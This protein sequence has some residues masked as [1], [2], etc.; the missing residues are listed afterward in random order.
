MLTGTKD[1]D[2]PSK[3]LNKGV[4]FF[5]R[6]DTDIIAL[7]KQL[8]ELIKI[9]ISQVTSDHEI[10]ENEIMWSDFIYIMTNP[11][12]RKEH[13]IYSKDF[14]K[15]ILL[16]FIG[17]SG[18]EYAFLHEIEK[19]DSENLSLAPDIFSWTNWS[20]E[21]GHSFE[22]VPKKLFLFNALEKYYTKVLI[23]KI[24]II[25][26]YLKSDLL[27][28]TKLK[29][30][31]LELESFLALP[32]F[33]EPNKKLV[34]IIGLINKPEGFDDKVIFKL[35]PFCLNLSNYLYLKMCIDNLHKS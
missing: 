31:G 1:E 9:A 20:E 26:N 23:G 5:L 30:K 17:V 4:K 15:N 7:V 24:P 34:G 33:F 18:C 19:F 35:Q 28:S 16:S 25:E 11:N 29:N 21:H 2:V 13:E 6:K 27:L 3:A 12:G 32:I 8:D 14:F 10:V 22:L